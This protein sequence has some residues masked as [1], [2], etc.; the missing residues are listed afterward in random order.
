MIDDTQDNHSCVIL[1]HDIQDEIRDDIQD[2]IQ[3]DIQ[4]D[5]QMTFYSL[6]LD[7]WIYDLC[8]LKN[9][10]ECQFPDFRYSSKVCT[11]FTVQSAPTVLYSTGLS[12]LGV[13]GSGSSSLRHTET[14][15][16]ARGSRLGHRDH[17]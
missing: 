1:N 16:G 3:I 4:D 2:D 8:A 6:E 17:N 5:I 12:L 11:V 7:K 14:R 13:G 9:V 15:I 10:T